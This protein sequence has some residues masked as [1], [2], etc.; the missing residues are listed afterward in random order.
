M[1]IQETPFIPEGPQP[2]VRETPEASP[3]PLEA[4]G[5]MRPAVE[6][7]AEVTEAPVALC[8][9]SV[10]AAAALGAQGLRDVQTLGGP[11]PA[12][13]FLLTVAESGERKSTSDKM[14]MRGVR[15]FEAEL[16]LDYGDARETWVREHAIWEK[17]RTAILRGSDE[18]PASTRADLEAL[19]REPEPPL[20]P[21]IV[22]MSATME[23]IVKHLPELRASLGI[24]TDEGG[25]LIGGH[26]MR[27][28]SKLNT[29]ATLAAM[30]DGAP[31]DRWRAGD[32][33]ARHV[34]RRFSAH[35][36]I[37]PSAVE[38]FI[39]DPLANGQG[40]MARFL[41][42][43]P[44]SRIGTRLRLAEVPAA[45]TEVDRLAHH[46][47]RLLSRPL[48][49]ADGRRN[50]LAPPILTLA[51]DARVV[52]TMFAREVEKA[53]AAGG[54]FEDCRAMASKIAEQAARLAGVMTLFADQEAMTITAETMADATTIATFYAREAARLKEAAVVPPHV[55]D[56]ERMRRWL[57][58]SWGEG[59]ISAGIAAQRGPFKLTERTRKALQLLASYGWLIEANGAEVD[60]RPRREAWR[61]V[62]S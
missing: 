2:L 20:R 6:A 37:Q 44:T 24:M 35:I 48:A 27:A 56:A 54:H 14:A 51:P 45:T 7:I 50:E 28:E 43:Q 30:W 16:A 34:G 39:N 10:L 4:L 47:Q 57:L 38:D 55:A 49:L 8:A 18:N 11:R 19:G 26:S 31:L 36:L 21:T 29:L 13:L 53:Q 40:L 58:T 3:Y 23:G 32:G 42:C 5:P 62:R 46:L 12:S 15:D 1:T 52:L 25:L 59:F 33:I 17:R 61:V 22:A 9:A 41:I 60:G